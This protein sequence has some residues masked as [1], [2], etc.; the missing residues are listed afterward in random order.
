MAKS[1]ESFGVAFRFEQLQCGIVL[2][3]LFWIELGQRIGVD[4]GRG[5]AGECRS[6]YGEAKA[7]SVIHDVLRALMQTIL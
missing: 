5:K 4:L 6:Q 7:T 2:S 3:V 1:R